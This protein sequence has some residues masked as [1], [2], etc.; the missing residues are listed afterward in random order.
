MKNTEVQI[1]RNFFEKSALAKTS[2]LQ[3]ESKIEDSHRFFPDQGLGSMEL[4]NDGNDGIFT[5]FHEDII[6]PAGVFFFLQI[7]GWPVE[8]PL[9]DSNQNKVELIK[10]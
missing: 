3:H 9:I 2:F 5:F 4:K 1:F 7:H 8:F 10:W 6:F